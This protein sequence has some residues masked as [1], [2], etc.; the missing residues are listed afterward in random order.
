M[1]RKT[2]KK[3]GKIVGALI[4]L[5]GLVRAAVA[6]EAGFTRQQLSSFLNGGFGMAPERQA[7]LFKMFSIGG[8]ELKPDM[9]HRWNHV[10]PDMSN[11]KNVMGALYSQ[12]ELSKFRI[13]KTDANRNSAILVNCSGSEH[14]YIL[15]SHVCSFSRVTP[16]C[17][18]FTGFGVDESESFQISPKEWDAWMDG[19]TPDK[20]IINSV[21]LFVSRADATAAKIPH[22][23]TNEDEVESAMMAPCG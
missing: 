10:D 1:A 2:W 7:A 14:V 18:K 21:R 22:A 8:G 11:L 6:G 17:A 19:R 3:E 9:V 12:D 5:R 20:G 16:I 4:S 15:A 13:I 23:G